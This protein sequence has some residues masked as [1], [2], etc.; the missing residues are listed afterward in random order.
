M[1][2]SNADIEQMVANITARLPGLDAN[3]RIM[4][5]RWLQ[6]HHADAHIPEACL[7]EYLNEW[8]RSLPAEGAHW[9]YRLILSEIA[10]WCDLDESA[11]AEFMVLEGPADFDR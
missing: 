10:W 2:D 11:L 5:F 4:L 1:P 7:A 3:R 8:F 6:A 9:E